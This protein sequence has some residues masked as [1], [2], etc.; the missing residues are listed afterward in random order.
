MWN[1][2]KY[3]FY[4]IV[5]TLAVGGLSSFFTSGNRDVY[6][7]AKTPFLSPPAW[8]FPVVWAVLY[9]L[10]A[11]SFARVYIKRKH[12]PRMK[13]NAVN[14]YALNLFFNFFWSII[15]FD[16]NAYLLAFVWLLL[17]WL[18]IFVMLLNFY[19]TDKI[20]GFLLIPYLLWVS[21][22]GY[23]NYGVYALNR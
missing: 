9:V 13:R 12:E 18:V 17:L 8:V 23:L 15:F 22:A 20:A 4:S 7:S 2:V 14:I 16:F 1:K 3:Y 21:F 10:M 19:R 5:V 11:V 6:E